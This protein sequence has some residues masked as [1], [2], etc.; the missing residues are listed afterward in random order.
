MHQHNEWRKRQRKKQLNRT[1][2]NPSNCTLLNP[3]IDPFNS[4]RYRTWHFMS[5]FCL[6]H[7]FLLKWWPHTLHLLNYFVDF[8]A[9]ENFYLLSHF[10]TN[11]TQRI[12]YAVL[13]CT[14]LWLNMWGEMQFIQRS[15]LLLNRI[16][17]IKRTCYSICQKHFWNT[18]FV[19]KHADISVS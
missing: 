2:T 15:L 1:Q 9:M 18:K 11:S 10:N 8:C 17:I 13:C 4:I 16:K 7:F 5:F 3:S 12:E 14:W 19:W 6:V